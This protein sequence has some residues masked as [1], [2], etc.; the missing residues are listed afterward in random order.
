MRFADKHIVDTYSNLF[1]GLSPISKKEL[2]ENLTKSLKR[3]TNNKDD[4]FY[5]T[6]GAFGSTKSAET[7]YA[8][9]KSSRKFR[10]KE[11]NF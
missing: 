10:A 11:I 6:F 7:I 1:E 8:E 2:I 5:K 3:K 9:I 4:K